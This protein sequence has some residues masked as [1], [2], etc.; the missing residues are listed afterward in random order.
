[1]ATCVYIIYYIYTTKQE[2]VKIITMSARIFFFAILTGLLWSISGQC[3]AQASASVSYTVVVT[4]EML[5]GQRGSGVG[6]FTDR[7]DLAR[8]SSASVSIRKMGAGHPGEAF[9]NY[10]A[11]MHPGHSP[12]LFESIEKENGLYAEAITSSEQNE[13]GQY[14]VTMEFN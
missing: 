13:E 5:A 14:L 7:D 4:E 2:I 1:M 3:F 9:R 12:E 11:E 8:A 10:Q 6:S